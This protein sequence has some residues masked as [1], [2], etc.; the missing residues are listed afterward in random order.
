IPRSVLI[1]LVAVA[2]IYVTMNLSII[3]VVPWQDFV[4]PRG[5][6]LADPPPPVVSM[7]IERIY[8][9]GFANVFTALVLWTAFGSCFALLLGYSRI[10][11][12]AAKDGNFFPVFGRLHPTGNFP[13]VSLLF[14]GALSIA[15]SFFKLQDVINAL[16]ATRILVQFVGQIGALVWLRWRAPEMERPF[17]MRLY[18]VPALVAL[19]GWGFLYATSRRVPIL[20]SLGVVGLGAAAYVIWSWLTKRWPFEEKS[21]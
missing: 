4:P 7:F 2:A 11:Y 8:G 15:F 9:G 18:P 10:P 13:H 20:Y 5:Q 21:A 14:I 3:S 19:C 1:S 6:E 16:L 12:A 17:R